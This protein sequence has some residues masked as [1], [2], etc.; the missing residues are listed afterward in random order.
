MKF[1]FNF[2]S[3]QSFVIAVL[4][5]RELRFSCTWNIFCMQSDANDDANDAGGRRHQN[6]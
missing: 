2:L 1:T 4:N 6:A 3:E 5:I